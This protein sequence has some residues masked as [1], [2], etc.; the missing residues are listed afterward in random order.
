M[1]EFINGDIW[2]CIFSQACF[3]SLSFKPKHF[4][5]NFKIISIKLF[6]IFL[7]H[8]FSVCRIY[9]KV[10]S[11]IYVI[12]NSYLLFFFLIIEAMVYG[13]ARGSSILLILSNFCF[14]WIS[15]FCFLLYWLI[16]YQYSFIFSA[17]F[18]SMG[19]VTRI[20]ETMRRMESLY[21]SAPPVICHPLNSSNFSHSLSLQVRVVRTSCCH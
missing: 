20:L 10:Y 13:L 17:S 4:N 21:L 9:R 16:I 1:I 11:L 3:I 5:L 12:T 7:Y 19:S 18:E 6:I 8:L 2:A 14:H 15:L